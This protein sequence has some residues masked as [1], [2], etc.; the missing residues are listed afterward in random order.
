MVPGEWHVLPF[1]GDH[2]LLE[3]RFE[4]EWASLSGL[5]MAKCLHKEIF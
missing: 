3:Q 4:V 1:Q 2:R 5:W